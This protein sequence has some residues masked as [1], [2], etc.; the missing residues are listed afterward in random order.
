[1]H[2]FYCILTG[3]IV[4]SIGV[5]VLAKKSKPQDPEDDEEFHENIINMENRPK[6]KKDL[7]RGVN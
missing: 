4:L 3:L 5:A 6:W 1:M 2:L 7:E